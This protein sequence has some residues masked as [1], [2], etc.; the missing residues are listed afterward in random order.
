MLHPPTLPI[1]YCLGRNSCIA[2]KNSNQEELW[3]AKCNKA[4][5]GIKVDFFFAVLTGNGILYKLAQKIF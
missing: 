4:T 2:R 1:R 5:A 3:S